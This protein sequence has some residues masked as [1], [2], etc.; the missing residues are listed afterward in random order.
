MVE[1]IAI[2][3]SSER[4]GLYKIDQHTTVWVISLLPLIY[5]AFTISF[6]DVQYMKTFGLSLALSI[7][8]YKSNEYLIP[9]FKE[10][11]INAKLFGKDLNKPG[12]TKDKPPV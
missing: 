11:L 2:H 7:I 5:A 8:V 1:N 9:Q 10:L 4:G 6:Y 12:E 3:T